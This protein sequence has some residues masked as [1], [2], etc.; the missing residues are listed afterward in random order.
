MQQCN[1]PEVSGLPVHEQPA[2]AADTGGQGLEHCQTE[3]HRRSE[4]AAGDHMDRSKYKTAYYGDPD[5]NVL[6]IS[7]AI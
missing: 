6:M 1:A 5:E 2:H 4:N 3:C 7:K